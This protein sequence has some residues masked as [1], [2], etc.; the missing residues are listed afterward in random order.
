MNYGA[1]IDD[2][3]LV[4]GTEKLLMFQRKINRSEITETYMTG[5]KLAEWYREIRL[6]GREQVFQVFVE[7]EKLMPYTYAAWTGGGWGGIPGHIPQID[8]ACFV[9]N[10]NDNFLQLREDG[11][12]LVVF[13]WRDDTSGEVATVKDFYVYC[14]TDRAAQTDRYGLN[15][16][17][18]DGSLLYHS[19][20]DLMRVRHR[21]EPADMGG[22]SAPFR[23]V[24]HPPPED[25]N[26]LGIYDFL[27]EQGG[28][29]VGADKLVGI[30]FVLSAVYNGN[31]NV[32]FKSRGR[33]NFT[34]V[35]YEGRVRLSMCHA[36]TGINF[37][38]N[39]FR[40]GEDLYITDLLRHNP[41]T[42][43]DK[44]KI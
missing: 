15:I 9:S 28:F 12:Y 19:G 3:P 5:G 27:S 4:L 26:G 21:P 35:L 44:P 6:G 31:S 20:W 16:Y 13:N 18:P 2:L 34:A 22:L 40:A 8:D 43:I 17:R 36:Y 41:I 24:A 25:S 14:L 39:F 33:A 37:P 10:A 42:V 29:Y 38:H 30:G 7:H 11:W 23:L 32:Y 1:F